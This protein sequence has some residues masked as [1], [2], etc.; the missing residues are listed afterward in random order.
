MKNQNKTFDC[1]EMKRR[2]GQQIRKATQ[3]LTL[4][5]KID[6][7][8]RRSEQFRREIGRHTPEGAPTAMPAQEG[9]GT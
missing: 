6:Y 1:V 5:Q 4:E 9:P 7:W 8:H 2:G 3:G